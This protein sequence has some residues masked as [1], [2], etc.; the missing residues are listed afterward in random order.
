MNHTVNRRHILQGTAI[1]FGLVAT[2]PLMT[3]VSAYAQSPE[4]PSRKSVFNASERRMVEVLAELIIPETDTPGAG[5]AGVPDFIDMMVSQWYEKSD[6]QAFIDGLRKL[7][8]HCFISFDNGF[9]ECSEQQQIIALEDTEQNIDGTVNDGISGETSNRVAVLADDPAAW[10]DIP[11][12]GREFFDQIKSLTVLGYYTSE[13]GVEHELIYDPQ[14]GSYDG[15]Q[16]FDLK[17][18][19]YTS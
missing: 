10:G 6:K 15:S 3:A 4:T 14:P 18:K 7:N 8:H 17:G 9:L 11:L 12:E 2:S 5:E 1:A 19:H 13:V 16:D